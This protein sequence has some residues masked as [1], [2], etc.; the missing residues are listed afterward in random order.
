VARLQVLKQQ[1]FLEHSI[2]PASS[3]LVEGGA[4]ASDGIPKMHSFKSSN[5]IFKATSLLHNLKVGGMKS[6][7]GAR[8]LKRPPSIKIR[9][10]HL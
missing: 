9:M 5:P 3:S 2:S 10:P 4:G 7:G 1:S 8:A 6:F